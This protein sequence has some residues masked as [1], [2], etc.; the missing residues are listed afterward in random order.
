M[1]VSSQGVRFELNAKVLAGWVVELSLAWPARLNDECALNLVIVGCVLR[2]NGTSTAVKTIQH[3][4]RVCGPMESPRR[5]V[6]LADDDECIL[7]LAGDILSTTGVHVLRARDGSQALLKAQEYRSKIDILL[8]DVQMGPDMTGI[9]LAA[10][11]HEAR[12]DTRIL[13]MSGSDFETEVQRAG[14]EFIRKPFLPEGLKRKV[15]SLLSE[16]TL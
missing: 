4:F 8:S 5:T 10:R 9:E 6:L 14:W 12:P 3:A 15:A 2:S 1:A 7:N 11:L 16:T 13:L